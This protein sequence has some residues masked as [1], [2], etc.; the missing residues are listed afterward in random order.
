MNSKKSY[1]WTAGLALGLCL[2][3]L[4]KADAPRISGFIDTTYNY[5]FNRPLSRKTALRSFDARTDTFLLN[6]S[7]VMIDGSKDGIGYLVKLAYGTDASVFKSGGTGADAGLPAAPSTVAY[8]F[9]LEEAYMTY[10]CPITGLMFKAGKFVTPHGIEV[11]ESKDDFTITRGYMFGLAEAYTHVGAMLGYAL[12]KVTLDV[13]VVN[14]WDLHTDNNSGKTLIAK[15]GL[16]LCDMISGQFSALYGAEKTAQTVDAR[17]SVDTVWTIKPMKSLTLALQGDIGAEDH[18]SIA[19]R[20]SDGI[21]DG[22]QGQWYSAGIQPKFDFNS[23]ISL[24]GRYEWFSDLDGARTGT[25]QVVQNL[26]ICPMVNVTDNLQARVEY[27]HDWSTRP[28]VFER[29][30]GAFTG[31]DTNTASVEFIYKF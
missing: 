24:G 28:T 7:Q 30:L 13:G 8:N 2:P 4:A 31:S 21:A 25:T 5:D 11:I 10:K 12:P 29:E 17:T 16:P 23:K 6:Q 27:R 15:L 14:G 3:S 19:D 22:G 1:L 26:T 18:T 9:E 20:N